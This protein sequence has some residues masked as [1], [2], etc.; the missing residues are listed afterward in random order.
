M[1]FHDSNSKCVS[2]HCLWKFTQRMT[3]CIVQPALI[4]WG[5]KMT[6]WN[7][8]SHQKAEPR[9]SHSWVHAATDGNPGGGPRLSLQNLAEAF[10][11]ERCPSTWKG[12]VNPNKKTVSGQE[13]NLLSLS[14]PLSLKI[15]PFS[16]NQIFFTS[17]I[18]FES[19]KKRKIERHA[20]WALTYSP[21]R[22]YNKCFAIYMLHYISIHV[23]TVLRTL[24]PRSWPFYKR[25]ST[26]LLL[27]TTELSC[28]DKDS[29]AH[30]AENIYNVVL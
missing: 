7:C 20:L 30:K 12:P 21:L 2:N 27:A 28:H 10:Q 25:A 11:G 22:Y 6:K 9:T 29:M 23:Y 16:L 5:K 17:N 24:I 3:K 4:Q 1:H 14:F 8:L 26:W 19:F 13:K 18:V 15:P